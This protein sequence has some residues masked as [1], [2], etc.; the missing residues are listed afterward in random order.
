M[1]ACRDLYPVRPV[2][3]ASLRTSVPE[4]PSDGESRSCCW[5]PS[6]SLGWQV[7]QE[8]RGATDICTVTI[9]PSCWP[10]LALTQGLP[11]YH[12]LHLELSCPQIF[13]CPTFTHSSGVCIN[14]L[15]KRASLIPTFL[16]RV[17]CQSHSMHSFSSQRATTPNPPQSVIPYLCSSSL[18]IFFPTKP[19]SL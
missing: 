3:S 12:S 18:N 8:S 1:T 19:A 7:P 14:S 13:A 4:K 15:L 6:H 17:P 11:I 2:C 16:E 9:L 5:K 10:S